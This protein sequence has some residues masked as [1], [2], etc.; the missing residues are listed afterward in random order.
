MNNNNS[1]TFKPTQQ[2]A[3]IESILSSNLLQKFDFVNL[4]AGNTTVTAADS[5]FGNGGTTTLQAPG[6]VKFFNTPANTQG[7]IAT[8]GG[9]SGVKISS[10]PLG[11][12]APIASAQAGG[13]SNLTLYIVIGAIVVVG[14]IAFAKTKRV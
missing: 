10:N 6:A 13:T 3:Q 5:A 1:L 4:K 14:L 7:S 9:G 2:T 11:A 8:T 12:V